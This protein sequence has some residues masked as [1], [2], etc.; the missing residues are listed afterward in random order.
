MC[1]LVNQIAGFRGGVMAKKASQRHE[2][3]SFSLWANIFR[4]GEW[5]CRSVGAANPTW[6]A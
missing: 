5:A 2:A 4:E 1:S 3:M 6:G